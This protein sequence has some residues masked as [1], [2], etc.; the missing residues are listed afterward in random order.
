VIVGFAAE[1]GDDEGGVL[2]HARRKLA[3]KGCDLLVVNDVSAGRVFGSDLTEVTLL[4]RDGT[5]RALPA[6]SK[7]DVAD[8]IW[9]EVLRLHQ[10]GDP[11]GTA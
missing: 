8:A 2:D 6:G 11:P 7:E 4:Y 3:A 5:S 1:T 10:V 9:D